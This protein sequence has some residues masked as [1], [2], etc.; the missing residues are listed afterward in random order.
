MINSTRKAITEEEKY[1]ISNYL[2][3]WEV[4]SQYIMDID[5]MYSNYITVFTALATVAV[6]ILSSVT[7]ES[8]LRPL[9]YVIPLAYIV[10]FGFMSYQF[11]IT[12]ILR[13][14]LASIE[15]KVNDLLGVNVY[16]WNSS[17]TET[18][19]AHR[20]VPNKSLM[21]P[22]II[23]VLFSWGLCG[24]QTFSKEYMLGNVLYWVLVLA[25]G[26]L[27]LLPFF[28][29]DKVR[30]ETYDTEMIA[31]LYEIHKERIMHR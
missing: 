21:V 29:N 3:E 31:Y 13:G 9:F 17:L 15:D 8:E 25:L 4:L 1:I 12:A 18:Y 2:K 10:V 24:I 20:N 5:K 30:W 26:I 16:M 22:V 28:R 23:F 27:V 7:K 6:T 19:L 14:Y 11:R